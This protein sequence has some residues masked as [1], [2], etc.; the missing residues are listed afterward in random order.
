MSFILSGCNGYGVMCG[1]RVSRRGSCLRSSARV[2]QWIART[3][4]RMLVVLRGLKAGRRRGSSSHGLDLRSSTNE[5]RHS[6]YPFSC[7][8]ALS[9][10]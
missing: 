1:F 2:A 7:T 9:P 10:V 6:M 5:E 4:R 3:A 8:H